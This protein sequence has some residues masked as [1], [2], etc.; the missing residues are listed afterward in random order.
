MRLLPVS[1]LPL[2]LLPAW[3][4]SPTP[5]APHCSIFKSPVFD[6][7]NCKP[8]IPSAFV[9]DGVGGLSNDASLMADPSSLELAYNSSVVMQREFWEHHLGTWPRAI[10][11]TAAFIHTAFAGITDTLSKALDESYADDVDAGMVHNMVNSYFTQIVGFYFGQDHESLRGQVNREYSFTLAH[12]QPAD[13]HRPS[14]TSS[15][16][17]SAG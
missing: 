14:T 12:L 17:S 4:S 6:K 16:S 11:W 9:K 5:R 3:G 7:Q 10:D 8:D 2:W 15:G 1:L 13:L